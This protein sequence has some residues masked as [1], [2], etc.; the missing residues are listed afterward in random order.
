MNQWEAESEYLEGEARKLRAGVEVAMAEWLSGKRKWTLFGTL[1]IDTRRHQVYRYR[2]PA[3]DGGLV[4]VSLKSYLVQTPLPDHRPASGDKVVWMIQEA[5]RAAGRLL[6]A[7]VDYVAGIERH[8]SG[9]PHAHCLVYTGQVGEEGRDDIRAL[10]AG[11]FSLGGFCKFE[12]PRD[13]MAVSEYA[14]KYVCKP[15]CELLFSPKL[16]LPAA[17]EFER[18]V[19]VGQGR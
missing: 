19:F 15:G 18:P 9:D 3:V 17:P 5:M 2:V 10:H 7:R 14:A 11:W 1:T 6:R 8:K 13:N 16:H 12:P 4:G